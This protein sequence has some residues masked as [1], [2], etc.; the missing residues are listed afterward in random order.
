M[1]TQLKHYEENK[2]P[3]KFKKKKITQKKRR[4]RFSLEHR[5]TTRTNQINVNTYTMDNLKPKKNQRS[6]H[7]HCKEN[8]FNQRCLL[9][10]K[11]HNRPLLKTSLLTEE[12]KK[13]KEE[14]KKKKKI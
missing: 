1:K 9:K 7:Q 6:F 8:L 14:S 11:Y 3:H 5:R 13:V 12:K 2:E 10:L 4:M